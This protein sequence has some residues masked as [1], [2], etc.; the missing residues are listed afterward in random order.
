MSDPGSIRRSSSVRTSRRL[1]RELVRASA[2]VKIVAR[3]LRHP[4]PVHMLRTQ[5]AGQ[6]PPPLVRVIVDSASAADGLAHYCKQR[7]VPAEIDLVGDEFHVLIRVGTHAPR[8]LQG[9]PEESS[10]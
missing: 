5:L 4:G 8:L 10:S 3:G 7:Q 6:E 1:G 9:N 2:E